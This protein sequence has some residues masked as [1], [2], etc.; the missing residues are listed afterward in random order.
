[1]ISAGNGAWWTVERARS[2]ALR[3]APRRSIE[4]SLA[5]GSIGCFVITG[6]VYSS[7]QNDFALSKLSL[8]FFSSLLRLRTSR[9][10]HEFNV[11]LPEFVDSRV[12]VMRGQVVTPQGLGIVGIRVSVDRE[13]RFGFTLTRQ[14]GWWVILQTFIC[15]IYHYRWI[16]KRF[17]DCCTK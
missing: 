14:G 7:N 4:R 3:A 17:G 9:I 2:I 10:C 13:S 16:A 11:C 1:M 6:R 15:H 8:I 5:R 12:A